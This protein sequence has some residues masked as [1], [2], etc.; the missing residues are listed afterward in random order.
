MIRFIKNFFLSKKTVLSLIVLILGVVV[1]A[2]I[3]PQ[4][5]SSAPLVV[6]R[7]REDHPHWA[8]WVQSLGLDHIYSTPWFAALL[9]LFLLSLIISTFEQIKTSLR[10]T[11]GKGIP[12]PSPDQE[13]QGGIFEIDLPEEKL[14]S[15][16][17]RQGYL[18]MA[19][20]HGWIRFVRQPWGYWGNVLL[21]LGLV[22]VILSSLLIVLTQKRGLLRLTEGE[23]YLPGNWW[24]AEERGVLAGKVILPEAVGLE[25]VVPEFWE[26]DEIKQLSTKINFV[27]LQGRLK[28]HTLSVNQP[29]NYKGIRIYQGQNFGNAFF[30]ELTDKEGKR[31]SSIIQMMNP[32]KRE[33]ASYGNFQLEGV[34]YLLKA[35]Y[36]AD[37][38]RKLM[39]SANPLLVVRLVDRGKVIDEISLKQGESRQIGPYFARLVKV[40]RWA[41]IIFTDITGMPGIFLGFFIIIAGGSLTYFIPPREFYIR[42]VEGGFSFIWRASR[43]E[44]FY[45][46]E[47]ERIQEA[48]EGQKPA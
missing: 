5:F 18:Q 33:K 40:S 10:K 34:P 17:K 14:I 3:F 27:D 45:R 22:V 48:F 37:A 6:E 42:R 21:H 43:F 19:R 12:H 26:T 44:K 30:I 47:Y 39:D 36:F 2:Y 20:G 23:V 25:S 13:G 28:E 4:R 35:K 1:V 15:A 31:S 16:A 46:E 11:F 7:W 8:P 41:E 24:I 38:E 9:F 29:V 32:T